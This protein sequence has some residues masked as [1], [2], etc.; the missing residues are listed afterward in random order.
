MKKRG[1][2][3]ILTIFLAC[4]FNDKRPIVGETMYQKNLNSLF[5]DASKSPLKKKDLRNFKGLDFFPVD[6]SYIITAT[7]TKTPDSPYLEMP[8]SDNSILYYREYG[9]IHFTLKEKKLSLTLYQNLEE[10]QDP[11]LKDYLFLP[12]T[13]LTSGEESYGGGR[14]MNLFESTITS[15]NTI[16]LNFNNTYNPYCA[17]NEEY[18]CPLTPRKNHLSIPITAGIKDFKKNSPKK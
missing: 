18:S 16:E 1:I 5:K 11:Q 12:F 4:N 3:I 17:Y 8:S 6:S 7:L 9:V 15:E 14:F 2:L 10:Q 13:D